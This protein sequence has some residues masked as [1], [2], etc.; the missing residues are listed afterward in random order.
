[1]KWARI[2]LTTWQI[3]D[4]K[5]RGATK[6]ELAKI[7]PFYLIVESQVRDSEGDNVNNIASQI[8][9]LMKNKNDKSNTKNSKD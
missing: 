9:Q 4:G 2:L 1:M 8:H 7:E 3:S 6:E 5:V